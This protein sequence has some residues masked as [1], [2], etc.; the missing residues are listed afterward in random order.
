VNASY[1]IIAHA[2]GTWSV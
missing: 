2:P 1:Y